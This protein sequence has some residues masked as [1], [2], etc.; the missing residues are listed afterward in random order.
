MSMQNALEDI[1]EKAQRRDA[2]AKIEI[3]LR[4]L[5][6]EN[7]ERAAA[8]NNILILACYAAF[9]G[10]WQLTRPLF[11]RDLAM[12]GALLMVI[13]AA[14]FVFHEVWKMLFNMWSVRTM[15]EIILGKQH[16]TYDEIS[17]ALDDYG[18]GLA[19]SGGLL[20]KAWVVFF[21]ISALTGVGALT[22]MVYLF[23]SSFF[24]PASPPIPA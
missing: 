2:D 24:I 16:R 15:H 5:L 9:F 21:T 13:S 17:A 23:I 20:V 19:A 10:I 8:Y 6:T 4:M 14:F 12:T 18:R 11:D 22:V 7:F 3:T 1:A